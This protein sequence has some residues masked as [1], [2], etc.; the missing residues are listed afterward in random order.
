[1]TIAIKS[2]GLV[3]AQGSVSEILKSETPRAATELPWAPN[4]W[5]VSRVCFPA[6]EIDSSLTGAARWQALARKALGDV[7]RVDC[8]GK[9][10]LLVATCNGSAG[11]DWEEAFDTSALLA[12]TPW[13]GD[14]LPVFSSSCA[15]GVQALYAARHL[16]L[17]GAVEE[18][19]V[20]AVDILARSNHENF[21][22][23]RV[24]AEKVSAPWQSTSSGFV[25]G[26]AAVVLRVVRGADGVVLR[27]P[28]LG[29]ELSCVL[30]RVSPQGVA[31]ILGQGTGPF[32]NDAAELAAFS[33]VID[34]SVPLTTPLT[35][36]GHTLGASGLLSIALGA[37]IHQTGSVITAL[38]SDLNETMDQ[39][40]YCRGGPPW[41]PSVEHTKFKNRESRVWRAR[42][43]TEGGHGGPPLQ[44]VATVKALNGAC[45][46]TV[47]GG[48]VHAAVR[49]TDGWRNS[50]SAGPL[51]NETLKQLA[52]E[53]LDH[54]PPTPPDVLLLRMDK[55]LSP[56]PS[57]IIGN[58]LLPS[59]VLEITPG[60]ASQLIARCWG[61]SGPA[62]CLVG[63]VDTDSYGLT[64]AFQNI[65]QVNLRGTGDKRAIEWNV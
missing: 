48:G 58:R 37:L 12:G 2:I 36:F 17:A 59:A 53:S 27:G 7:G 16:L 39:R 1:M 22:S 13:A 8:D 31:L 57:A 54:R 61:F 6:R 23:L 35:H 38:T 45:G 42:F 65:Y 40:T 34:K 14:R 11:E 3:T 51:M 63:D 18:V 9:T 47:I 10:P 46:A 55:P 32:A 50:A 52:R 30:E 24:L 4:R 26:E 49:R 44:Y 19:L 28:V 5:T 43:P 25:L 60:F 21:E 64:N 33:A 62:L 56:P 20:L 29:S 15:S 41:P